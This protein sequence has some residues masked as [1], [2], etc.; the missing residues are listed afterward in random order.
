MRFFDSVT[1]SFFPPDSRTSETFSQRYATQ[2]YYVETGESFSTYRLIVTATG[3]SNQIQIGE[4]QLLNIVPIDPTGIDLTQ[5][6]NSKFKT[7]SGGEGLY[8]NLSGQRMSKV[9]KGIN[10]VEGKKILIK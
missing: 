6:Q 5:I 1:F 8:Y 2:F 9:Q 10:I 7:H 4:I 3:G